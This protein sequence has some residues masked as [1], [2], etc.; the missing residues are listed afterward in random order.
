MRRNRFGEYTNTQKLH[1]LKC[2]ET[3]GQQQRGRR[4]LWRRWPMIAVP[5]SNKQ[6][7]VFVTCGMSSTCFWLY[8]FPAIFAKYLACLYK[9]VCVWVSECMCWN[10]TV[11]CRNRTR[12]KTIIKFEFLVDSVLSSRSQKDTVINFHAQMRKLN[13][14]PFPITLNRSQA[15]WACAQHSLKAWSF[16]LNTD[17]SEAR[18]RTSLCAF[19]LAQI[20]WNKFISHKWLLSS[21][22]Y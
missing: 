12:K 18:A 10:N 20:L 9:F 1:T 16:V 21:P 15:T 13:W 22:N 11:D 8:F 19:E 3:D 6:I 17:V 14:R 4:R 2:H 5:L 7:Q